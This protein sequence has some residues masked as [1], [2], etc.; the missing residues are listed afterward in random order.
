MS[1]GSLVLNQDRWTETLGNIV[2]KSEH[3]Q[4]GHF[5]AFEVPEVLADDLRK[6]FSKGGPAFA[7]VPGKTGYPA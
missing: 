7:V 6:M 2:F 1:A 3:K 4:G 5:A